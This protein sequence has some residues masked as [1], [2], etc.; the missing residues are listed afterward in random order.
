MYSYE[1]QHKDIMK[2]NLC[3]HD[4]LNPDF[5]SALGR[6]MECL[7]DNCYYGRSALAKSNLA[8]HNIIDNLEQTINDLEKHVKQLRTSRDK[9][10]E[11]GSERIRIK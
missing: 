9:L 7:C 6:H 4:P 2:S 11:K 1:K 5:T 10:R 8:M 3:I